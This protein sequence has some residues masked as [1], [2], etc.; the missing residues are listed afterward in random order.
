MK[1]IDSVSNNSNDLSE[2]FMIRA[3]G[4]FYTHEFVANHLITSCIN[5]ISPNF[6]IN[7]EIHVIDPFAGDGR[8]ISI[9]ISKWKAKNL[10]DLKW[11]V[12]LWDIHEEG[13][14]IA[15]ERLIELKNSGLNITINIEVLD[16]FNN[17]LKTQNRFDVVLTNPPWELL[18]PDSRELK[19]LSSK[20]KKDYISNMRE[21]DNFLAINYPDS[22]PAKKFAGWGTNLSRVGLD[23]CR[24]ICKTQGVIGIVIPASF[25]ADDQSLKLRHVIFNESTLYDIAYFPAE[26]KLYGRAD[27]SSCTLLFQLKSS[28]C[29][30]FRF[31]AYKNDLSVLYA[32]NLTMPSKFLQNSGY[33]IP[34]S[35]GARNIKLLFRLAKDFPTWSSLEK[36][37]LWAGREVDETGS[38]EWLKE[39]GSGLPFIK[40]RMVDR[41][42]FE[43]GPFLH[44]EKK[45]LKVPISVNFER[46]VWRDVSRPSQKRRLIATLIPPDYITG[47]SLGVAYFKNGNSAALRAVL[48]I[49][50]SLCFEFQLRSHLATGHVSLSALRKVNIPEIDKLVSADNLIKAVDHALSGQVNAE[51]E[52]DA[53]VAKQLYRLSKKEYKQ[54][55]SAFPKLTEAE[56]DRYLLK[57]DSISTAEVC[58]DLKDI[59]HTVRGIPNHITASLSELDMK[60]IESVPQ[61]G[62]WKNIPETIPSNRLLK[63]RNDYKDGCGSRSTY[64]GRLTPNMPSYTINTYFNRPGN[65]CHIHYDQNRVLSQREAARLQ[66]FPDSFVFYGS[67]ASINKQIGNAVP[68][69]LAF[70]IAKSIGTPG[71][72]VDL[73]SGAGGLG[74]GFI[75]AGWTPVVA[76]DIEPRFL[77]TYAKNVHDATILG[78]ITDHNTFEQTVNV[79]ENAKKRH[80]DAPFWVLG[81]P[82]CQGFSTGG[83]RN[84][85][86]ERNKLFLDYKRFLERIKPDGF[87]FENVTGLLNMQAGMVFNAVKDAFKCVMPSLVGWILSA[88]QYGVPQRRKRVFLVGSKNNNED[89]IIE[90]PIITSCNNSD[91]SPNLFIKNIR[92]AISVYEALSDLPQLKPGQNGTDLEYLFSPKYIY[93]KFMRGLIGPEEYVDLIKN[94]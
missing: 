15:E 37:G 86:D 22:Q 13:L 16:S 54:V 44:V 4:R 89:K 80:S 26:A 36:N 83:W 45:D 60:I 61:G 68:P 28:R 76:N 72:F 10:P 38:S 88:E 49:M 41:F 52:I 62:N 39:S 51:S 7:D 74:L 18:K 48:G 20:Q 9:L 77:E 92:P 57:Y 35:M 66:S 64:Y 59:S 43:K 17:A 78:S 14:K 70:Q 23:V 50:N 46:I 53:I 84:V 67:Q 79:S 91:F 21:Y 55:L 11:R 56:V 82:P 34:V 87:V 47:N 33:I 30:N 6:K 90:P 42:I 73:F 29:I 63:I 25:F 32:G 65:G 40:G 93:Q 58:S 81:G 27:V 5:L 12:H 19:N 71:F 94:N 75:W 1:H 3:T 69:L 85:D 24:Q 2:D 8:L 31:T